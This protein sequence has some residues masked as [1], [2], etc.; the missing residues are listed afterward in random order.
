[1]RFDI[2]CRGRKRGSIGDPGVLGC[3]RKAPYVYAAGPAPGTEPCI[4]YSVVSSSF[5][6][7]VAGGNSRVGASSAGATWKQPKQ[8]SSRRD[9]ITHTSVASAGGKDLSRARSTQRLASHVR[10]AAGGCKR[11]PRAATPG[12]L[13][14]RRRDN[15]T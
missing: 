10:N 8:P 15:A 7:L 12:L 11:T 1:M 4:S 3:L 5:S 2:P 9:H 13:P 6:V 14:Q